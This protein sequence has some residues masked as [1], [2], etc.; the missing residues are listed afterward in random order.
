MELSPDEAQHTSIRIG[1]SRVHYVTA[2]RM[3]GPKPPGVSTQQTIFS[4]LNIILSRHRARHPEPAD[5]KRLHLKNLTQVQGFLLYLADAG[6]FLSAH[7]RALT[8]KTCARTS[9]LK[10]A[11][12]TPS[13]DSD[14]SLGELQRGRSFYRT[15][16]SA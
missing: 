11:V 16:C 10:R 13:R 1:F 9:R 15:A 7:M 5:G 2:P 3:R 4:S 12:H 14:R 8:S 6:A